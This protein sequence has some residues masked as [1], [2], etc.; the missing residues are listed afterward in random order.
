M[1]V[2]GDENYGQGIIWGYKDQTNYFS[3]KISSDGQYVVTAYNE[4]SRKNLTDNW[5]DCVYI[6]K[7]NGWNKL[8]INKID[9]KI[10][11]YINGHSIETFDFYSLG[12]NQMGFIVG[13]KRKVKIDYLKV[14]QQIN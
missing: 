2:E 6:K 12:G 7:N 10:S 5:V 4:G 3:F 14:K 9:D 11:F 1:L 13:E 8:K